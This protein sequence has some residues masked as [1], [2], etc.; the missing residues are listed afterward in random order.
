MAKAELVIHLSVGTPRI[1]IWC[2]TCLTSARY[3]VDVYRLAS[4]GPHLLTA[5]AGCVRCGEEE[6][7]NG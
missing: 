7:D 6:P 4:D 1:H 3:E 5:I 2:D